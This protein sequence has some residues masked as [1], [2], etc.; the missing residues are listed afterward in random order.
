M[1]NVAG[2]ALGMDANQRRLA[3][4]IAHFQGDG[5]LSPAIRRLAVAAP[6]AVDAERAKFGGKVRFGHFFERRRGVTVH[7]LFG[8]PLLLPL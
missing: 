7:D 3:G 4:Q 2:Q 8:E 5:F 6:K 1:E